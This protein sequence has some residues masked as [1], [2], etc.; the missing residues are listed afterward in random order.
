MN[1]EENTVN[2]NSIGTRFKNAWNVFRGRDPTENPELLKDYMNLGP[3][4]ST[5][6]DQMI[7][8]RT[9]KRS[10]VAAIYNRIAVDCSQINMRHV[11]TNADGNFEKVMDSTLNNCLTLDANIDQTGQDLMIDIVMKMFDK[12]NVAIV[13]VDVDVDPSYTEGYRILTIR[14]GTIIEWYK[15]NVKISLYDENTGRDREVI[16]P[17]EE[18]AIVK[19]PFY[20]V[21]NEYNSLIQ[22]LIRTLNLIEQVNNSMASSRL[23]LIIQLPY[24]VNSENR[25]LQADK[26]RREIENQLATSPLGIAYT[27]GD[28]R[29]VQ[30]N[31]S[32][33]NNLYAQAVDLKKEL[34]DQL[35]INEGVLNGTA[36]DQTMLNYYNNIVTPILTAISTEMTRRFLSKNARTRGQRILFYR[37]PFKLMPVESI[38]KIADTFTR[39]EIMTANEIRSKCGL[40]PAD[41]PKADELVNSNMGNKTDIDNYVGNAQPEET[42]ESSE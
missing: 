34:Y 16:V 2:D 7:L 33:E 29:V 28:E 10:I 35:G 15:Q 12:G 20:S 25:Q 27:E 37:D 22:R 17:K 6:P 21:M 40:P 38:A 39:N 19:N 41:D 5:R 11:M 32:V 23:D 4:Y 42:D 30:L 13:P 1:K 26:R 14:A 31:R 8:S 3:A 18:V 24:V 9:N 36:N